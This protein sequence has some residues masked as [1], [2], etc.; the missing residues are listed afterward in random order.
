MLILLAASLQVAIGI[1]SFA[2]RSL[3]TAR[4]EREHLE[5]FEVQAAT[6]ARRVDA[7]RGIR[8]PAWNGKRTFRIAQCTY[9]DKNRDV[10]SY[11]LV[12]DDGKP[13]APFRP[14]QFLTFELPVPGEEHPVVRCYSLSDSPTEKQHY[15]VSIKRLKPPL[16]AP[17]GT[18]PGVASCFF[19]YRL[20]KGETVEAYAPAGDFYL[21]TASNRPVVLVAGGIGLTPMISMLNWLVT[22]Q[23]D[24]E[25]WLFY[26]VRNRNEH[27]MYDHLE[28]IRYD[29][30]NVHMVIA[31]SQPTKTCQLG[32]DYSV[33]G[34]INTDLIKYVLE[35]AGHE[36][37]VCGPSAMMDQVTGELEDEGVPPEDIRFEAFGPATVSRKAAEPEDTD[38]GEN[39]AASF[40]IEFLRSKKT[41]QWTPGTTSLL[42]LAEANGVKAR[43]GCRAGN[44]GTCAIAVKR[45][46]V[47]H[48]RPP[49]KDL[50][51]DTCLPCIAQPKSDLALDI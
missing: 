25:V 22:S 32:V 10:C 35:P 3:S 27:A 46:T 20:W 24:R 6:V 9:E 38:T 19:H 30:P 16:K 43:C 12:P 36:F 11:Y 7:I 28:R 21:D 42:E 17:P 5:E 51:G 18:P 47:G 37:Y 41:V 13:I 40:T 49:G 39:A 14:G 15:R 29:H 31:Y 23:P 33:E 50:E 26:G 45:G 8:E 2:T 1:Y 48:I 44:C 34:H 4:L